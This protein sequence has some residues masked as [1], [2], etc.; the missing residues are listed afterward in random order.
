MSGCATLWTFLLTHVF[1]PRTIIAIAL[2]P[3]LWFAAATGSAGMKPAEA[4][5]AFTFRFFFVSLLVIVFIS[6]LITLLQRRFPAATLYAGILLLLI[7]G[8]IWYG[9]RFHGE[10]G[11][12]KGEQIIQYHRNEQGAW[13]GDAR[14]P[15]RIEKVSEEQ[16]GVVEFSLDSKPLHVP[17]GGSFSWNGYRVTPVSVEKAP[18]VTI[19][20]A[21]GA[22]VEA[23]YY[24]LG[25]LPPERE[26]FLVKT[27]PHRIYLK[28]SGATGIQVRVVRDKLEIA[29]KNLAWG[30]KLYYDGHYISF[31]QGEPWVRISVV[32]VLRPYFALAGG[33]LLLSGMLVCA[34]NRW[35]RC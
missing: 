34:R 16:N 26:F 17:L 23:L 32:K 7:Q 31:Q 27:M 24:K 9:F 30:E 11:A 5:S 28:R 14:I 18:L 12:G 10:A 29:K 22:H 8:V 20:S 3:L 35:Q 6:A 15:A 13:P 21:K 19:D 2:P 1:S 4:V 33:I 25:T